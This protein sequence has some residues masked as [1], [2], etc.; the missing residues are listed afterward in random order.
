M[1]FK[2]LSNQTYEFYEISPSP[3]HFCNRELW[4]QPWIAS[5]VQQAGHISTPPP[6]VNPEP[7]AGSGFAA[8]EFW[9]SLVG[10]VSV[11]CQGSLAGFGC[12]LWHLLWVRISGFWAKCHAVHKGRSPTCGLSVSLEGTA[13][14]FLG[15]LFFL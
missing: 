11:K 1:V 5:A 8:Q 12:R 6:G 3:S 15:I 4:M 7:A 14:A 9:R 10:K 13:A 2:F